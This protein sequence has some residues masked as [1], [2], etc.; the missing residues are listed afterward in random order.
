MEVSRPARIIRVNTRNRY[1]KLN[2][3]FQKTSTRRNCLS[4]IGPANC[5]KIPETLKKIKENTAKSPVISPNFLVW[6]ICGKAQFPYSYGIFRS[7]TLLFKRPLY[8]K[9][10]LDLIMLLLS[11]RIFLLLLNK[12][13]YILLLA[14]L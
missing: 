1:L 14:S 7:E 12:Y 10:N 8:F 11:L 4:Y 2:H 9:F 13:F 3:P 5:N 6:K